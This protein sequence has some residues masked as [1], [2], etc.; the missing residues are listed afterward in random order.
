MARARAIADEL[1]M[2]VD[3]AELVLGRAELLGLR[4]RGRISAGGS[5]RLLP[6]TDGW[7]AVNLAR[8]TDVE[9][10]PAIVEDAGAGDDP[11]AALERFAA[12]SSSAEAA[13][14]CQLLDVP[15]A[16][17]DDPAVDADRA[18]VAHQLG[19]PG[20]ARG[21]VVDLSAMWAGPLC[22]RLLGLGGMEIVK[23]ESTRRPDGAR[24]GDPRFFEWLHEGHHRVVLDFEATEGRAEL[25]RLIGEADVVVESSRPRALAAIGIDATEV[26]GAR[27]GA[28]WVSITGYGREGPAA[29]KVAFGDDAAVAGGLVEQDTDGRP[30][31][32]GD[33]V[34][35]PLSGLY[36]AAAAFR[37]MT[38]GGGRLLDVS[39]AS[40]A[41]QLSEPPA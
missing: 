11:W 39:M 36:A 40:V 25:M 10:V 37:S 6:A 8:P 9:A 35:D 22:A 14:R 16:V 18:A 5:C 30:V 15:G 38:D 4:S 12:S 1:P 13:A 23:V 7:V 31:F 24:A 41:K 29:T 26:V 3:V 17:L 28:T 2:P 27:A 21:L 34:A 20:D 19:T 33:A 32:C